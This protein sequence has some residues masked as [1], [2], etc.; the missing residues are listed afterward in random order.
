MKKLI[1]TLLLAL[2]ASM[3]LMSYTF[4]DVI[5]PEPSP[6]SAASDMLLPVA[7]TVVAILVVVLIVRH[8]RNKKK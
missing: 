2:P 3:L 5:V 1:Q 6:V 4:A 7:A 8:F